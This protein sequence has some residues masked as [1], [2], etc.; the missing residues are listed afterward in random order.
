MMIHI[1]PRSCSRSDAQ[2]HCEHK[3]MR[4]IIGK[5]GVAQDKQE[6]DLATPI[7]IFSLRQVFYRADRIQK[8]DTVLP[9]EALTIRDGWCDDPT[10]SAYNQKISLPHSARHET[11]WR[12]DNV[13]DLIVVI[14]YNDEKIQPGRGSA[15]FMHLQ[16][17]NKAPTEGCV[18][19]T[20]EDLRI[21]LA[22][23]AT[24]IHIHA[25][26]A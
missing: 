26:D 23:G 24:A 3:V 20:E 14:G 17:E 2:L 1:K 11:L 12:E 10:H 25:S 9:V 19:L 22:S 21:V 5:N 15:I 18:A 6:G 7:G 13:Y 4:A 16:R 8:P